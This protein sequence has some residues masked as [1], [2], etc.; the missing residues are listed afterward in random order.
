[1][2]FSG[3][4]HFLRESPRITVLLQ[5]MHDIV[6]NSIA[7][8]LCQFLA[9][10]AHKFSRASQRECD[11]EAEHA[12]AGALPR[13]E[14]I[15]NNTSRQRRI[16]A[17]V[18]AKAPQT[19]VGNRW[20]H[21]RQAGRNRRVVRSFSWEPRSSPRPGLLWPSEDIQLLLPLMWP[22]G[23][24]C[25]QEATLPKISLLAS[26]DCLTSVRLAAMSMCDVGHT[27]WR[28]HH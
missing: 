2:S 7:F 19:K 13:S 4:P 5:A 1:M 24:V 8:F 23:N 10:S 15:G 9:K 11:G 17:V 28:G 25:G 22:K 16:R 6:S 3:R 27:V 14:Q 12:P 21:C 26:Q 18:P 20:F